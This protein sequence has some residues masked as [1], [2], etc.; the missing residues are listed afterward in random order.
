MHWQK[1]SSKRSLDSA[2]A[3]SMKNL[4]KGSD[5]KDSSPWDSDDVGWRHQRHTSTEPQSLFFSGNHKRH[6][7]KNIKMSWKKT[8]RR[9][10]DCPSTIHSTSE[11]GGTGGTGAQAKLTRRSVDGKAARS[12]A[13]PPKTYCVSEAGVDVR[14]GSRSFDWPRGTHIASDSSGN[15]GDGGAPETCTSQSKEVKAS[16]K[17]LH[18]PFIIHTT[19]E[20]GDSGSVGVSAGKGFA[21][22]AKQVEGGP[23]SW[24][25][26][27]KDSLDWPL[28]LPSTK[29]FQSSVKVSLSFVLCI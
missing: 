2:F 9:S 17:S 26:A 11:A 23:L 28:A 29:Y 21:R 4:K 10:L 5:V 19:S 1:N 8:A 6:I 24:R 20:A 7:D 3:A 27:S 13:W 25:T 14:T 22:Q 15:W 12:Q 18:W 16:P